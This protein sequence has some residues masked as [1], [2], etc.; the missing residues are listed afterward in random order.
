VLQ[1]RLRRRDRLWRPLPCTGNGGTTTFGAGTIIIPMDV[2]WQ[3]GADVTATPSYCSPR[4]VKVRGD[5]SP[6]KAYGLVFFLLRHQVTVYM[7]ISPSKTSLDAV[8]MALTSFSGSAPVERYDWAKGKAV[9]LLDDTDYLVEYRGAP[10]LID[11]SQHDRVMQLLAADPDFAQF[12]T[13]GNITVHVAKEQFDSG[14]AK[15]ISAVPS[16]VALLVPAGDTATTQILV[17]YLA[18]AG[19]NFPGAGGTRRRRAD[20]RPA[21]GG[22]LPARLRPQQAQG[23]RLQAALVAPLGRRHQQHGG[24]ARHHRR[25]RQRGRR[26]LRRVRGHRH[27]RGPG[28]RRLRR[29]RPER[30]G[31]HALHDQRRLRR[32]LALEPQRHHQRSLPLRRPHQPLRAARGLPFA[33]SKAR[34]PTSTPTRGPSRATART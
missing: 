6:L 20:L 34:S 30:L 11:S 21:P 2:C 9:P 32:Q 16:R 13:A 18:S 12:R 19:L 27:A 5:D 26:S 23:E 7:A 25:L 28:G 17:R 1:P 8:D 3:R 33:A 15:S 22:R 24:A 14:I 31:G 4:N 29:R 10:F